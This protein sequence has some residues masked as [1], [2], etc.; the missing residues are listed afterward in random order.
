MTEMS[1]EEEK[2]F[3][4]ARKIDRNFIEYYRAKINTWGDVLLQ[5][6]HKTEL[7]EQMMER[8]DYMGNAIYVKP[9]AAKR[10]NDITTLLES[11]H[12]ELALN[13]FMIRRSL[14]EQ[15]NTSKALGMVMAATQQD[16]TAGKGGMYQ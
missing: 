2:L 6:W 12:S 4:I 7:L 5:L 9:G 15:S 11:V 13:V 14:V 10:I 1:E 3:E 16:A 8:E